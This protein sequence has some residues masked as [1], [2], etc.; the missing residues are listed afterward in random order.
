MISARLRRIPLAIRR[1]P[2]A[3]TLRSPLHLRSSLC[4][5]S[6]LV[7]VQHKSGNRRDLMGFVRQTV[8]LRSLGT[9]RAAGETRKSTKERNTHAPAKV[10]KVEEKRFKAERKAAKTPV[11]VQRAV[12]TPGP[13]V[14]A[15]PSPAVPAA[16]QGPPPGWYLDPDGKEV[17]RWWDGTKWSDVTQPIPVSAGGTPSSTEAVVA[18]SVSTPAAPKT[19]MPSADESVG[20]ASGEVVPLG[21]PVDDGTAGDE[22]TTPKAAGPKVAQ[23]H[24]RKLQLGQLECDGVIVTYGIK[25]LGQNQ[26]AQVKLAK[27][28][29]KPVGIELVKKGLLDV[30]VAP[31]ALTMKGLTAERCAAIMAELAAL[32][33]AVSVDVPSMDVAEALMAA[34]VTA[35][36]QVVP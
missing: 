11:T 28:G 16:P 13:S 33:P 3:F 17:E 30:T 29:R 25:V 4:S 31:G 6:H 21:A 36:I 2:P 7:T 9:A 26:N 12:A 34:G 24:H 32:Q 8:I 1:L 23:S 5:R 27:V 10:A 35:A 22:S 15:S 18:P 19:V 20:G 14:Q